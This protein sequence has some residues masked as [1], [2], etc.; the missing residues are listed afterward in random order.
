M[1]NIDSITVNRELTSDNELTNKLYVDNELD[2]NTI[3]R[4]N[5]TL[6]N[7]L[8]MSVGN[9]TYNLTKYNK[10]SISDITEIQFPNT[11][12]GLLQKWNIYC[13]N[14]IN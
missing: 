3:L 8:K 1:T 6:E 14:K 5:Q 10:I 11:G 7:Y 13:N 12:L 9:D 2:K 4:F